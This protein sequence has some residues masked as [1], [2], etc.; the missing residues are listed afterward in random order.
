MDAIS[1]STGLV[2]LFT[3]IFA[4]PI[5]VLL[6]SAMIWM[7]KNFKRISFIAYIANIVCTLSIL[8]VGISNMETYFSLKNNICNLCI[9]NC[10]F[11]LIS[12]VCVLISIVYYRKNKVVSNTLINIATILSVVVWFAIIKMVNMYNF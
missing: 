11:I 2:W 9:I 5:F 12:I 3:F 4:S 6:F 10:I 8:W 1:S 7:Y